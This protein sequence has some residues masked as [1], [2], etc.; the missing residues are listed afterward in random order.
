M[1]FRSKL[2][3]DLA[4]MNYFKPV[5]FSALTGKKL[6]KLMPAVLEAYAN[7][8]KTVTTG[9][10]NDILQSAYLISPVP[11]KNGKKDRKSVV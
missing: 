7:A 5:Y 10:L 2:Q 1:L 3:I 4:F 6:E 11:S 8:N 9:M